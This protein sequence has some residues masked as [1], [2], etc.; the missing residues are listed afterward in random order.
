MRIYIVRQVIYVSF[1]RQNISAVANYLKSMYY[2]RKRNLT[3]LLRLLSIIMY[4]P[5][6]IEKKF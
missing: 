2:V 3:E 5:S 4:T 1:S 6:C